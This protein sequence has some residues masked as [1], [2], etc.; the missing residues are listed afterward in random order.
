MNHKFIIVLF[1]EKSKVLRDIL[2]LKASLVIYWKQNINSTEW[3]ILA[4]NIELI[5]KYLEQGMEDQIYQGEYEDFKFS[6]LFQKELKLAFIFINDINDDNSLI[7]QLIKYAKQEFLRNYSA[8]LIENVKNVKIFETFDPVTVMIHNYYRPKIV[9]AGYNEVGKTT[10]AHLISSDASNPV[11]EPS[12]KAEIYPLTIKN[13]EFDLWD[14]IG[15][16][17]LLFLWPKFLKDSDAVLIV[18]DSNPKIVEKS[19]FFIDLIIK[20]IPKAKFGII[21]NKQDLSDSVKL[22]ELE[23]LFDLTN[24]YD[25]VAIDPKNR[26]KMIWI[27][28][29][30]LK[31]SGEFSPRVQL[32]LERANAMKNA[33]QAE[34]E[35]NLERAI[36]NFEIISD[37]SR[38]LG[39]HEISQNYLSRIADL[40]RKLE[41]IKK[42]TQAIPK[43]PRIMTEG[44]PKTAQPSPPVTVQDENLSE[45]DLLR[46]NIDKWKERMEAIEKELKHLEYKYM[47]KMINEKVYQEE[48]QNL[49]KERSD[50]ENKL[51]DAR[52]KMIKLI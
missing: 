33:E 16:E 27:I 29:D 17:K 46:K 25:M 11:Q 5:A 24:L 45:I 39:D 15:E 31:I 28:M 21:A 43:T 14:F 1:G 30:I 3:E 35:G 4:P 44:K 34:L 40:K 42:E 9:L 49:T 12:V 22:E 8:D 51:Y 41:N 26:E 10:I 2:I 18:T 47:G 23:K 32:M 52:F 36:S 20:D 13:L 19:K 48:K 38:K 6:Y 50:L 7:D 37:Y